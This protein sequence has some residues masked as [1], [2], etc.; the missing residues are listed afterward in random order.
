MKAPKAMKTVKAMKAMKAPKAMKTVTAMK[1]MKVM[2]TVTAKN[3]AVK[4]QSFKLG[5]R[6]WTVT[7]EWLRETVRE[8]TVCK[9]YN[10]KFGLPFRGILRFILDCL[11]PDQQ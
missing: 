1:A 11:Q 7:D 9:D 10:S 6:V 3:A 2:K 4:M 8:W 5:D